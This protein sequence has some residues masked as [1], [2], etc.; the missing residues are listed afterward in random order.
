MKWVSGAY[1]NAYN[2]EQ[3]TST[4]FYPEPGNVLWDICIG[5]T[6]CQIETVRKLLT[7]KG[8]GKGILQIYSLFGQ[9]HVR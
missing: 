4:Y 5:C 3:S 8:S 7:M 2:E 9:L 1:F 6:G